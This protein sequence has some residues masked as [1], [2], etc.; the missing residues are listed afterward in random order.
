MVLGR[1]VKA[2]FEVWVQLVGLFDDGLHVKC[3]RKRLAICAV[4][5]RRS[6]RGSFICLKDLLYMVRVSTWTHEGFAIWASRMLVARVAVAAGALEIPLKLVLE[7]ALLRVSLVA[8][9]LLKTRLARRERRLRLEGE[10]VM[11][12]LRSSSGDNPLNSKA[13]LH[14]VLAIAEEAPNGVRFGREGDGSWTLATG[15]GAESDDLVARPEHN[16]MEQKVKRGV[17]LTA[18]A[19]SVCKNVRHGR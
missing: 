18:S 12:L 13:F 15:D 3:E 1:R 9:S 8:A 5:W 10:L 17:S 19:S 16:T 11:M 6:R 4:G 14:R 7:V 2:N